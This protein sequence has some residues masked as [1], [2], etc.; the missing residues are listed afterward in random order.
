MDHSNGINGSHDKRKTPSESSVFMKRTPSVERKYRTAFN[1]QPE[2]NERDFDDDDEE[3]MEGGD[4]GAVGYDMELLDKSNFY[5]RR[6]P[7]VVD[8]N[9]MVDEV[10]DNTMMGYFNHYNVDIEAKMKESMADGRHRMRMR[11]RSERFDRNDSLRK[12]LQSR[13]KIIVPGDRLTME[14]KHVRRMKLPQGFPPEVMYEILKD[15]PA[16]TEV[17][18]PILKQKLSPENY[19]LKFKILMQLEEAE[20][21]IDM[22]VY[23]LDGVVLK[24]SQAN[25]CLIVQ[26]PGLAD[27][28]P[29]LMPGDAVIMRSPMDP[30][31]YEA[32][33]HTVRQDEI[34]IKPHENFMRTYVNDPYNL[35]FRT[36]R[37]QVRRSHYA[38]EQAKMLPHGVLFPTEEIVFNEDPMIKTPLNKIKFLNTRL[39]DRQKSA[40]YHILRGE[41]APSP[42]VIFGPPGTG[43]TMTIVEAILQVFVNHPKSRILAASGSNA[44]ADLIATKLIESGMIDEKIL[45]RIMAKNRMDKIP[46]HLEKYCSLTDEVLEKWYYHRIIVS[47]CSTLGNIHSWNPRPGFFSHCFIDE[48]AQVTEPEALLCLLITTLNNPKGVSVLAGD[49]YQLGPVCQSKTAKRNGLGVPLLA[50]LC[51]MK[52]YLRSNKKW[53]DYGFYDPRCI[54]KLIESY[55]CCSELIHMNSKLFYHSELLCH[56]PMDKD[57]LHKMGLSFPVIFDGTEGKD[58]QEPDNPSWCNHNEVLKC[59]KYLFQLYNLGLHPDDIGI[60]TP[61][62]KQADKL[63]LFITG[64]H[65]DPCK[66]ATIEEFQGGERRVIILSMVRSSMAYLKHDLKFNLGFIFHEKRF[67]VSTSRA[68]SLL[69]VVGDPRVLVEDECWRLFIG[70]CM[71][72][73][74]YTGMEFKMPSPDD[75]EDPDQDADDESES[76]EASSDTEDSSDY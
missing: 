4:Q 40:V 25:D 63:R 15:N 52:P 29:S 34:Y 45:V 43:K 49:P 47:T 58:I 33:I 23:D 53:P 61:Y 18:Y 66:I 2:L 41:C 56:P 10:F 7:R 71:L 8:S 72:N 67:N 36:S 57:L 9:Q 6:I 64:L 59:C 14:N 21:E 76:S 74:G 30:R 22:R 16:L 37:I 42:Y 73:N 48:A 50:R 35:M 20:S 3:D 1:V 70:Y 68:K 24:R 62:R 31:I 28:R 75:L 39:N 65:R 69:I 27:G 54:T 44:C 38:V 55:R 60:I 51:D 46:P 11:S 26:V 5:Q 19:E 17:K 12:E 13:D 32:V